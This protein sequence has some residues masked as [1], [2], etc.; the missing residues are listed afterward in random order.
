[1]DEIM[2][3]IIRLHLISSLILVGMTLSALSHAASYRWTDEKGNVNYSQH[4]PKGKDY[5]KLKN[6][7]HRPATPATQPAATGGAEA[8]PTAE[9]TG[10]EAALKKELAS[11]AEQRKKN[12]QT[13]KDNLKA[14]TLY[15][16]LKTPDGKIVVL[17]DKERKVQ[18]QR[19]SD[20]IK[21]YCD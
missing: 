2:K 4:P 3:L 15:R 9:N 6:P 16:R 8:S 20:A 19:A 10:G 5:T 18:K 13:A 14:Y 7:K 11:H 1:M 21:E 17:S 12:C